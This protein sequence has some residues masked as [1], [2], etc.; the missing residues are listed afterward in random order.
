[1]Y[2]PSGFLALESNFDTLFH[3]YKQICVMLN[4]QTEEDELNGVDPS[5]A[6]LSAR[7]DGVLNLVGQSV[8]CYAIKNS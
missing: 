8:I 7:E 4:N 5:V 1:M 6:A 3:D 2:M